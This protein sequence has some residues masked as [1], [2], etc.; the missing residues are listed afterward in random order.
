MVRIAAG[1]REL[2][3]AAPELKDET[4]LPHPGMPSSSS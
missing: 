1:V 4:P 3:E 2:I